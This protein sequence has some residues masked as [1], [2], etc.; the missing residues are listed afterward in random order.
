MSLFVDLYFFVVVLC[1][2]GAL[3]LFVVALCLFVVVL[4]LF[5]VVLCLLVVVLYPF[6]FFFSNPY[7]AVNELVQL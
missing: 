3:C 4:C 1:L 5:V 2:G 7:M 6:V